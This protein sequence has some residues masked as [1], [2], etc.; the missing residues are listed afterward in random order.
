L[1]AKPV[2]ED[3]RAISRVKD[4]P[5]ARRAAAGFSKDKPVLDTR[6]RPL[7]LESR[8][9]CGTSRTNAL[10]DSGIRRARLKATPPWRA[11]RGLDPV[12]RAEGGAPPA[13]FRRRRRARLA[14]GA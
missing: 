9:A 3:R 8:V 12:D 7:T 2:F 5:E 11:A 10:Q 6:S 4:A 13:D 14:Q 1:L